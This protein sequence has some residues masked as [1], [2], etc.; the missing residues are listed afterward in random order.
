MATIGFGKIS[1]FGDTNDINGNP[2]TARV[3][4][5]DS[6]GAV[7]L[8]LF[9]PFELRAGFKNVQ[10]DETVLYIASND[11]TGI[12]CRFIP[13]YLNGVINDWDFIIRNNIAL[14]I[15]G[16]VHI[17]GNVSIDGDLITAGN[18]L[19]EGNADIIG[20]LSADGD[21]ALGKGL[22]ITGG[23]TNLGGNVKIDGVTATGAKA[24]N[25]FP[26]GIDPMDGLAC[27]QDTVIAG[28]LSGGKASGNKGNYTKIEENEERG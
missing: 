5:L 23:N 16:D 1:Q 3:I 22:E 20:N 2:A 6:D 15:N 12:I 7:T 17:K 28:P 13:D 14:Q 21:A 11:G 10:I 18:S 27:S 24:F 26:G 19:V 8:D 9:I 25:G 4:P